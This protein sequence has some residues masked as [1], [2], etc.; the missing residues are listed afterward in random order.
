MN[1]KKQCERI[2]AKIYYTISR[3]I[4]KIRFR[5]NGVKVN[6]NIQ[7]LGSIRVSNS[8]SILISD[9]V[10][11]NSSW[12]ANKSGGGQTQVSLVTTSNGQ[13]SIGKNVG[14]S[15]SSIYSDCEVVIEDDVA[16]GVN[17]VITDSDHH[18][19]YYYDR[20]NG[21]RNIKSKPVLIKRGA[22]IGGHCIVLKGVTIGECSVVGAGSVV[23]RDIPDNE[24]W[25]GNPIRFIKKL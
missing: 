21:N 2:N 17:N 11:F 10:H 6:G 13:I 1:A 18:S 22:W 9:G 20:I 23:T 7:I 8:G 4:T 5:W 3:I 24:V 14:I 15:N 16:I 12:Y 25:G 19:I